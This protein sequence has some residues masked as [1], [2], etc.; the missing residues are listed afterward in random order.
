MSG[1]KDG[2]VAVDA[3][4]VI[5]ADGDARGRGRDGAPLSIDDA[6]APRLSGRPKMRR[7]QLGDVAAIDAALGEGERPRLLAMSVFVVFGKPSAEMQGI[8]GKRAHIGGAHIQQM[9]RLRRRVGHAAADRWPL[10]DQ[11]HADCIVVAQEMAGKKH[12]ARAAANDDDVL[13]AFR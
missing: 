1:G 11:C 6:Q 8:V 12:A 7:D 2:K 4:T 13:A 10:L 9:S 5:D 3:A